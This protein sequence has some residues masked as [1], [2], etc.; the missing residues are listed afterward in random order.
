MIE[1]ETETFEILDVDFYTVVQSKNNN[2]F[3]NLAFKL[4][5]IIRKQSK[6]IDDFHKYKI[7]N[8]C[9]NYNINFDSLIDQVE[10]ILPTLYY[11]Y[12]ERKLATE[13]MIEELNK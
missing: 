8:L 6:I 9:E 1:T 3:Y 13:L 7:F 12:P 2:K 11:N 5:K 4:A 10:V